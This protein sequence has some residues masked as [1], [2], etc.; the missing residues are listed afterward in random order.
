VLVERLL[1]PADPA[2]APTDDDDNDDYELDDLH[3]LGI[4]QLERLVDA[5]RR[6]RVDASSGRLV[7][8]PRTPSPPPGERL[9][10]VVRRAVDARH[11]CLAA[12]AA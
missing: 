8:R 12:A 1:R 10:E 2:P 9:K 11:D 4:D 3:T 7:L 6:L 5:V